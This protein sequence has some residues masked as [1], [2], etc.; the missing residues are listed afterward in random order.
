MGYEP[1]LR[2]EATV[3]VLPGMSNPNHVRLFS[4]GRLAETLN[5]SLPCIFIPRWASG[6]TSGPWLRAENN[7]FILDVG[8]E[9]RLSLVTLDFLSSA[10]SS[11]ET[12]DKQGMHS[13]GQLSLPPFFP[14]I[15]SPRTRLI[16]KL[17]I[18]NYL[19]LAVTR[20]EHQTLDSI[21]D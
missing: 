7:V 15:Q 3:R 14:C 2:L 4:Y 16:H 10:R 21:I 20:H 11:F 1:D 8:L 17:L 12:I 19:P 6:R 9:D 13:N 5:Q 18:W